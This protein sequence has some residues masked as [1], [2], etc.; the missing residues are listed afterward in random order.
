MLLGAMFLPIGIWGQIKQQTVSR[1]NANSTTLVVKES[2]DVD[3]ESLLE[4]Q[5]DLADYNV[6]DV[7][8]FTAAE[9]E[10][11]E[12]LPA[13]AK[14]AKAKKQKPQFDQRGSSSI[15]FKKKKR[16][17]RRADYAF[18]AKPKKKGKQKWN[19]RCYTF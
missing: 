18:Q 11:I 1:S 6:G 7:I 4:S 3:N 17:K 8:I 19:K 10:V 13:E 9:E 2:Q 16:N 15:R 12:T 5:F 14:P